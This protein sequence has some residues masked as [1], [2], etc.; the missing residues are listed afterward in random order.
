LDYFCEKELI[1]QTEHSKEDWPAVALKELVDKAL[2]SA[3]DAGISP[4]TTVSNQGDTLIVADEGQCIAADV[5]KR[6]LDFTS[7][8]SSKDFI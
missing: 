7:K 3:E 6:I 8:T 1:L 2:D 4:E 5:V